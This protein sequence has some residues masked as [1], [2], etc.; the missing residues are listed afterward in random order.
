MRH[1][2]IKS[3]CV[4]MIRMQCMRLQ[5]VTE[6][7]LSGTTPCTPDTQLTDQRDV[8]FIQFIKN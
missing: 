6:V 4:N 2:K 3:V 5:T 7:S 1:Y 8:I